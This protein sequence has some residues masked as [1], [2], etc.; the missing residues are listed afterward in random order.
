MFLGYQE[1]YLL[2]LCFLDYLLGQ[3]IRLYLYQ[4]FNPTEEKD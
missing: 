1:V 4:K 2:Y 3:V